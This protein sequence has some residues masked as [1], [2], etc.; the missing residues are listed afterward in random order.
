VL[1][2]TVTRDQKFGLIR[3]YTYNHGGWSLCY[4]PLV[5]L[6][7]L[8]QLCVG[9]GCNAE[10]VLAWVKRHALTLLPIAVLLAVV[11]LTCI[12]E[13]PQQSAL[14]FGFFKRILGLPGET[15]EM[16]DNRVIVNGRVLPS[17]PCPR[18]ISHG[19]RTRARQSSGSSNRKTAIGSCSPRGRAGSGI[20]RRSGC[21]PDST[22]CS[23]ATATTVTIRASLGR[24][25]GFVCRQSDRRSAHGRPEE[26]AKSGCRM[27][28]AGG[29]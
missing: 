29:R 20:I 15:I 1:G 5:V 17:R 11:P 16:R 25:G 12:P 14:R 27:P 2:S 3:A 26:I 6:V 18:R 10:A 21:C 24:P 22:S 7:R 13:A 19:C 9:G 28:D 4:R 8:L 23:A